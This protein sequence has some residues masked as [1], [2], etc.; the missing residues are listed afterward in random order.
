VIVASSLASCFSAACSL[1]VRCAICA[2]SVSLVAYEAYAAPYEAYAVACE[3]Y[4]A[5]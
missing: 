3:V 4:A 1:H 2:H 5:H